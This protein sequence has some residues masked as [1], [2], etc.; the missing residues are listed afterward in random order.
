MAFDP[1][2]YLTKPETKTE[3]SK[4]FD[5]D[6]YLKEPKEKTTGEKIYEYSKPV[7]EAAGGLGGAI[8]GTGLGPLG[9]AAGAGL[10]YGGAAAGMRGLGQ[11]LGYE[12]P[13]NIQETGTQAVKDVLTG[14]TGEV[15]GQ[16]L[17]RGLQAT[18]KAISDSAL[19]RLMPGAT[20]KATESI[21]KIAT[22]T[23]VSKLGSS[24][25]ETL[26]AQLRATQATRSKE[27]QTLLD[28]ATKEV[29]GN[30]SKIVD[31]Y[32]K[33]VKNQLEKNL[34]DLNQAEQQLII[35][36]AKNIR[37][38]SLVGMDKEIRRLRDIAEQAK[39]SP[40]YSSVRSKKAD[41]IADVLEAAIKPVSK[42]YRQA[43]DAYRVASQPVN[44]YESS[45]GKEFLEGSKDPAS[46]PKNFFKT[47][48]TVDNLKTLVGDG[49]ATQFAN[50]HIA[51][52]LSTE[53]TA[54]A[55]RSWFDKNKV[56]LKEFPQSKEA[57][58]NYIRNL[59]KIEKTRSRAKTGAYI[60]GG[61]V[62]GSEAYN[63]LKN[64]LGLF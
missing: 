47:K 45:V 59:E 31:N 33:Y 36:T 55:A 14:A 8:V 29:A 23:D 49:K 46:L 4:G 41:E 57:A 64:T 21:S 12:K 20:K 26:N 19:G 17:G 51:N 27:Y 54:K 43:K 11:Y 52:E 5:P 53:T 60:V 9:T 50:N 3:S 28:K 62:V 56:W 37:G 61:T 58:E 7:V 22:P 32:N 24:M 10:G 39:I 1:D 30:E 63:K 18:G 42:T 25:E 16:L 6:S 35:D 2:K 34:A 48:Y 15:G 13:T 38:K 40:G 44:V